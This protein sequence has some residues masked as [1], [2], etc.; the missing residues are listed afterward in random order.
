MR[1][2]V[3]NWAA[4]KIDNL[5]VDASP[6]IATAFPYQ[7]L[8]SAVKAEM[9]ELLHQIDKVGG[10][11]LQTVAPSD[12]WRV[13]CENREHSFPV[14]RELSLFLTEKF[15]VSAKRRIRPTV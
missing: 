6:P 15:P 5:P 12:V 11:S 8:P 13:R 2:K 10:S 3:M 7:T 1:L 9:G 4:S 14:P